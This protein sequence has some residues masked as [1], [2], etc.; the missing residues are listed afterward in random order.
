MP[1]PDD[2]P[3]LYFKKPPKAFFFSQDVRHYVWS[4][5]ESGSA[6]DLTI[7]LLQELQKNYCKLIKT[8]LNVRGW[9]SPTY[10]KNILAI[11]S[12][13]G[14]KAQS[15]IGSKKILTISLET[16]AELDNAAEWR[17]HAFVISS[18]LLPIKKFVNEGYTLGINF[19]EVFLIPEGENPPS[20]FRPGIDICVKSA[21]EYKKNTERFSY[22]LGKAIF[23]E[24]KPLIATEEKTEDLNQ[25]VA[26]HY[27]D[28]PRSNTWNQTTIDYTTPLKDYRYFKSALAFYVNRFL[29]ISQNAQNIPIVCAL[30]PQFLSLSYGLFFKTIQPIQLVN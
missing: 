12:R 22:Q 18:L 30:T 16:F 13:V 8:G 19:Q 26:A 6:S 7:A 20:H 1:N 17:E 29:H 15:D 2:A 24:F 9:C 14:N 21:A 10:E 28:N 23:N 27:S 3:F 5:T 25:V 4:A 11:L